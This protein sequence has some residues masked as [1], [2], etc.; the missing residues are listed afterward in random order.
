[1]GPWRPA[2]GMANAEPDLP[3]NAMDAEVQSMIERLEEE[4]R[5]PAER[6][7]FEAELLTALALGDVAC[8]RELLG[9]NRRWFGQFKGHELAKLLDAAIR[10]GPAAGELVDLLLASGVSARCVDDHLGPDYQHT[11]LVTAARAGRLDLVQR[12]V[13]AGAD[14]FWSSPTGANVLSMIRP[15]R[16]PQDRLED[17]TGMA[18]V[19]AWLIA[20]GVRIDPLCSDSRRK[21]RWA[22]RDPG[23]WAD[24]PGLLS[25]GIPMA[26]TQW[27]PFML[28]IALGTAGVAEVA[29][30]A[31]EEL[32]HRDEWNR[33]PFLLAVVAGNLELAE[34]LAERGSDLEATGHCDVTALHLAAE[35]N[36]V[37]L[38]EWLLAQG[39]S[40]DAR[41]QFGHSSLHT[42]VS[43]GCEEA[44]RVLLD[45][46]ADVQEQ[47]GTGSGL[48]HCVPLHGD[49]P[50]L[51]LLVEKGAEINAV[52]GDGTWPLRDAC[53]EGNAQ[54]VAYLLQA[55]ADPNLTSTGETAL[56]A[57]VARDS[58]ECIQRLLEAGADV[59]AMD[60]DGWTCLFHLRSV[61]VAR[62]L[63]AR[64]ADPAIPDQCGGL[65]EN[66]KSMPKT[67][68]RMLQE[69]RIRRVR[70]SRKL[71]D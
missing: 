23:G 50:L 52:F 12:L 37:P 38:I 14:L 24:V 40:I 35:Y 32:V 36:R 49:F 63:L 1:M 60:C 54:A 64:G 45:K 17:T 56:F 39:M 42:A 3:G 9:L 2:C 59:N 68:R 34:A 55:G 62:H 26:E 47:D 61:S 21:L 43:S 25:L 44:A 5:R 33:T 66:W 53:Q 6:G 69:W 10:S 70:D 11:P 28:R 29:A 13:R 67:V 30:L 19:R 57:A 7:D 51:R 65:P 48:L 31:P 20:E 16:A 27:T 71:R 22:S 58:L 46:G 18:E 8:C 4:L 41:D 15:S